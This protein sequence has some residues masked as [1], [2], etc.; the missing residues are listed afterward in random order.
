M[1]AL[2]LGAA[3]SALVVVPAVACGPTDKDG[4]HIP[5]LA[6]GIDDLLAQAKLPAADL[7]KVTAL[8]AQI[9]KLA[10]AGADPVN[11]ALRHHCL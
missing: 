3:L 4:P 6:A 11:Q 7:E 5:P 1:R 2:V 9:M 8:R 10:A